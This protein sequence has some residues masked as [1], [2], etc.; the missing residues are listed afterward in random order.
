[1]L[2]NIVQL[3]VAPRP[4][5]IQKVQILNLVD[6]STRLLNDGLP[7]L[8]SH[9]C[10]CKVLFSGFK[11][12]DVLSPQVETFRPQWSKLRYWIGFVHLKYETVSSI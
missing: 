5:A 12:I 1:M 3:E 2:K 4:E 11:T 10:R 6:V 8:H 7:T 9:I